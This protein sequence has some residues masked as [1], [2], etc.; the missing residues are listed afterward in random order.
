M[1]NADYMRKSY[2]WLFLHR[3]TVEED[4]LITCFKS[5]IKPVS[6]SGSCIHIVNRFLWKLYMSLFKSL[7]QFPQAPSMQGKPGL[8]RHSCLEMQKTNTRSF[9]ISHFSLSRAL[10]ELSVALRYY[11]RPHPLPCG[12]HITKSHSVTQG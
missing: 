9:S 3:K 2:E 11:L 8:L 5:I 12:R 1:G 10:V 6:C 7:R 4:N